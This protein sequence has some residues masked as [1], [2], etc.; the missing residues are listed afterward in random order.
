LLN[1]I[2]KNPKNRG[3]AIC[4]PIAL[5]R[6]TRRDVRAMIEV[7]GGF[8]EIHVATPIETCESRDRKGLCARSRAGLIPES[9]A[10]PIPTKC[11]R[12]RN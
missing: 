11:P 2:T 12:T 1:E 9:P 8:V 6:Q 3:I 7:V 4:T 5:Y 10:Y